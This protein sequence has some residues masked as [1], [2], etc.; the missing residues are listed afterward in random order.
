MATV[1]HSHQ[2]FAISLNYDFA[3]S[4]GGAPGRRMSFRFLALLPK[5]VFVLVLVSSYSF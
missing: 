4:D 2:G 5:L 3:I 1:R